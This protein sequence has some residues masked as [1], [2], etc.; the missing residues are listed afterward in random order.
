MTPSR[1]TNHVGEITYII[2]ISY[3][4]LQIYYNLQTTW[5]YQMYFFS[6]NLKNF[7]LKFNDLETPIEFIY[8][9]FTTEKKKEVY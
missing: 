8:H 4:T 3:Y 6:N 2:N 1:S 9:S 7:L 5:R